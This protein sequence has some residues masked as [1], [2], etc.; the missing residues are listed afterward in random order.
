MA[1]RAAPEVNAGSMADIAFLL[2]IFF[3]VTTTI[4]KD[5]GINRKLPP[6]DDSEVEPPIIKQKNIF[7]VSLN[8]NNDLLVEDE[9]MNIKDLRKAA[10]EFLDNGGDGTCDY[11][12]GKKDPASSDNPDK[13]IISLKNDRETSYAAYISVQNELV[14]AYNELR[15]RR[16]LQVG[17]QKGFSDMDFIKMQNN[18]KDVRWNG[19]KEKLKE[20]IDQ[21]KLE[22]PQKLS[23]VVE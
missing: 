16:A 7:T 13:A 15:N 2:L 12:D 19:N 4:E 20:V 11:C 17:P 3:L 21:I 1:K 6:I 18:Y 23:E 8:K 22:I 9:R 14:A 10:V 5:S